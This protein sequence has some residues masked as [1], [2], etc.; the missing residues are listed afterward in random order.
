MN[1]GVEIVFSFP[2]V[3]EQTVGSF[4]RGQLSNAL[5]AIGFP[6]NSAIGTVEFA[7]AIARVLGLAI[8]FELGEVGALAM[9]FDSAVHDLGDGGLAP[10]MEQY[11]QEGPGQPLCNK[12]LQ[13]AR[14]SEQQLFAIGLNAHHALAVKRAPGPLAFF[15]SHC[16]VTAA[17][18][19][20]LLKGV[21][22]AL[23]FAGIERIELQLAHGAVGLDELHADDAATSLEDELLDEGG[24][25]HGKKG[26]WARALDDYD[27]WS[28]A[29][30]EA[31][32]AL[33]LLMALRMSFSALRRARPSLTLCG[34]TKVAP[35]G[36]LKTK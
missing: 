28:E 21:T 24:F 19:A 9:A 35:L 34:A 23:D 7:H 17:N 8:S 20:G 27:C 15:A 14:G 33:A 29:F 36:C 26:M 1:N 3:I 13:R 2:L 32:R 16:E 4:V 11:R 10:V 25:V 6:F 22:S 30:C 31:F 5:P 18:N 12:A